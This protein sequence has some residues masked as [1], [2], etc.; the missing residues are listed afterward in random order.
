[1][2]RTQRGG[3]IDK[4][5]RVIDNHDRES[6]WFDERMLS[7]MTSQWSQPVISVVP[8]FRYWDMGEDRCMDRPEN[9]CGYQ[10]RAFSFYWA[11]RCGVQRGGIILEL[12]STSVMG[13]ATLGVDKHCGVSPHVGRYGGEYGYPHM[14]VDCNQPL[15]FFDSKFE[16][17]TS[18]HVLEHLENVPAVMRECLRV[19]KAGGYIAHIT[20]DMAYNDRGVIDPTHVN[21]YAADDFLEMLFELQRDESV[22]RFEVV[23]HNTLQNA[24]SFESVIRKQ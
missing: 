9:N 10:Q 6:L 7:I 16:A 24:F 17:V 1:M 22:P 8:G 3:M 20:P 14:E 13:P 4:S 12:G 15:P 2:E 23:T 5:T 11:I 19:V 21:E 18:N